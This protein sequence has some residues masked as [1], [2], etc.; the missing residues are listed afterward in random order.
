MTACRD[1]TSNVAAGHLGRHSERA[2]FGQLAATRH[3]P[4]TGGGNIFR[5]GRLED[6]FYQFKP[7]LSGR[8][9]LSMVW[10]DSAWPPLRHSSSTKDLRGTTVNKYSADV[11]CMLAPSAWVR[12][13]GLARCIS[14]L[15]RRTS[16]KAIATHVGS[17]LGIFKMNTDSI[18]ASALRRLMPGGIASRLSSFSRISALLVGPQFLNGM[19]LAMRDANQFNC[20]PLRSPCDLP[21]FWVF[22]LC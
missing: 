4:F 21:L 12:T 2:V 3:G 1:A 13:N 18:L 17:W 15:R 6:F 10:M 8:I 7:A 16:E 14:K 5:A 22:S 19:Q 20:F 9:D 11:S